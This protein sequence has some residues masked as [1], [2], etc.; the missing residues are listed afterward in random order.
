MSDPHGAVPQFDEQ[1][2]DGLTAGRVEAFSDGVLAIAITL[3]VLQ[4]DAGS[5]DGRL[6]ERLGHRWPLY[7]SYLLSFVNIGTVWLNHHSIFSRLRRVDHGLVVL[8]LLLL[9]VV[10]ALPFPT[11][12][13]G[14]AL[15]GSDAADQRTAALLYA[16]TFLFAASAFCALWLWA[17]RGRRLI[18]HTMCDQAIRLRT[19]R[20]VIAIPLFSIP[21]FV[22]LGHPIA[23]V[24][25]D[26]AIIASFLFSDGWLGRRIGALGKRLQDGHRDVGHV[27]ARRGDRTR[28]SG[29]SRAKPFK[30][31][32]KLSQTSEIRCCASGAD[33]AI[34]HGH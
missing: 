10:S 16:G 24:A 17:S 3:L 28:R 1:G 13:L 33:G 34:S 23:A 5:G 30:E 2:A 25:I 11:K 20:M 9:L 12:V 29:Q 14:E 31:T 22:A 7:T 4:L 32:P 18:H 8:N 26:G 19:A 21:C 6:A 15:Q 27:D